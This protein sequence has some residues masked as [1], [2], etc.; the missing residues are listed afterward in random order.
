MK[1]TRTKLVKSRACKD[2]LRF[3]DEHF[4]GGE[5]TQEE[6][7]EAI[8]TYAPTSEWQAWLARKLRLTATFR[9]WYSDGQ[10]W[11]EATYAEGKLHGL[12]RSWY[13]NG[14]PLEEETYV[15]GKL[16][17]LCRSWYSD[18]QPC[19]EATYVEGKLHGLCRTWWA[20]G[21]PCEEETWANGEFVSTNLR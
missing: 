15:E 4:P 14:T 12:R 7:F 5:A 13:D 16:H 18:G 10:P 17:G 3:F 6:V 11:V 9:T 2:G 20:D 1:I 19:V 21:Q 8:A